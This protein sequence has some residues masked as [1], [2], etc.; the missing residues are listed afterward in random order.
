MRQQKIERYEKITP[1]EIKAVF[2]EVFFENPRRLNVKIFSHKHKADEEK[3]KVSKNLNEAF[4][5]N[6]ENFDGHA[7]SMEKIDDIRLF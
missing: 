6:A 7:I 4:Y 5:E 1:R 3:R 2:R